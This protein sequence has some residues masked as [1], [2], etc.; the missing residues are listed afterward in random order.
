M[1]QESQLDE[2]TISQM[3]NGDLPW[4]ELKNQIL[5][6][7]KDANRFEAVRDVLQERVDWDEPILVPLND[8]LFVVG[9]E[10]RRIVKSE[11][12]HEY[13]DVEDNWKEESRIRVREDHE[14][15]EGFYED[16]MGVDP[17]WTFELREFYCPECYKLVDVDTVPMGY[18]VL[19]P[20]DPDIDTFYEEWLGKPAPDKR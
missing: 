14:D 20:F 17:D 15:F 3:L 16:Q 11:C 4:Q 1:S 7:P 18:P 2:E 19:K 8:H 12:G 9:K 10:G 6:D 5:P 13:C